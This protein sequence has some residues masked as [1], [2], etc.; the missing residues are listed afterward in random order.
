MPVQRWSDRIWMLALSRE[1]ELTEDLDNLD[2]ALRKQ[3]RTPDVVVDLSGVPSVTSSTLAK[4]LRLRKALSDESAS[5]ILVSPTDRVWSVFITAGLDQVFRF[6][7]D[8]ATALAELQL[9]D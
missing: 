6:R 1:P 2:A 4:L 3:A 9:P 5:L 8:A 7:E